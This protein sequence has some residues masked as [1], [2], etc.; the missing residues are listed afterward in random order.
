MKPFLNRVVTNTDE[1][2]PS[3]HALQN[4][5]FI[6]VNDTLSEDNIFHDSILE[7]MTSSQ[8][9]TRPLSAGDPGSGVWIGY[10][11]VAGCL[12]T[13]ALSSFIVF[14]WQGCRVRKSAHGI[15]SAVQERF[16]IKGAQKIVILILFF[17]QSFMYGGV[18][19]VCGG[20]TLTFVVKYLGWSTRLASDVNT[21]FWATTTISRGTGIILSKYF[22]SSKLMAFQLSILLCATLT[23]TFAA[24]LHWIVPWICFAAAGLGMGSL[25]PTLI[26]WGHECMSSQVKKH[27]SLS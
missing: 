14:A 11:I 21:T 24:T 26:N 2:D 25:F 1:T 19:I 23:L 18:E 22:R 12:M 7:N 8:N 6:Y 16:N 9:I 13:I 17:I 5:S 10:L 4:T 27:L 3:I 20:L 15:T